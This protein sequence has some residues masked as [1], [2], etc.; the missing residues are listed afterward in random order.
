[1]KHYICCYSPYSKKLTHFEIPYEVSV[2]I[3]QLE[4]EILYSSGGVQQLYPFRFN[5][6]KEKS[7]PGRA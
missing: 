2:Y 4:A 1:M 3:R 5:P 7:D 6:I